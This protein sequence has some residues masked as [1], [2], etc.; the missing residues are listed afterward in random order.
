MVRMSYIY[1]IH[2]KH[3]TLW[4]QAYLLKRCCWLLLAPGF[5]RSFYSEV[6]GSTGIH[7]YGS[8]Y[9]NIYNWEGCHLVADASAFWTYPPSGNDLPIGWNNLWS[10]RMFWNLSLSLPGDRELFKVERFHVWDA[11]STLRSSCYSII[12]VATTANPRSWDGGR[13]IN[14][15]YTPAKRISCSI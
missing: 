11:F 8:K 4:I 13:L 2:I 14:G 7:P 9:F 3:K 6:F 10:G 12:T 5:G 15:S 1:Y